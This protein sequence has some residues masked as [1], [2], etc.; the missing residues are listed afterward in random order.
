MLAAVGQADQG[1]ARARLAQRGLR[2]RREPQAKL[3]D[4]ATIDPTDG[5]QHTVLATKEWETN[6]IPSPDG[7]R[8]LFTSNR[9]RPGQR[10]A[11]GAGSSSTR[12]PSTGRTSSG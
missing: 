6:P 5:T 12:W 2:A 3:S 4:I 11:S 1:G 10:T 8:I 7:T 9:D